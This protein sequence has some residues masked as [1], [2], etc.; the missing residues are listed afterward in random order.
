M[1]CRFGE[2]LVVPESYSFTPQT[3]RHRHLK[4]DMKM[5]VIFVLSGKGI[6]MI[7]I[8]HTYMLF[9]LGGDAVEENESLQQK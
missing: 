2:E 6:I 8:G 9:I 3:L 1:A 7:Y 5:G 4:K